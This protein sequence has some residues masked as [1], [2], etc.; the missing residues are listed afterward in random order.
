M[1]TAKNKDVSKV[2]KKKNSTLDK[3]NIEATTS[4]TGYK[5]ESK[6]KKQ[7]IMNV[8]ES[9]DSSVEQNVVEALDSDTDEQKN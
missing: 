3:T 9:S 6:T 4:N 2:Q 5:K 8:S 1:Q 7:K